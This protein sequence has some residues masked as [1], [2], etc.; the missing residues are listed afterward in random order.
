MQL[1]ISQ[2]PADGVLDLCESIELACERSAADGRLRAACVKT[3]LE[4]VISDRALLASLYVD[5]ARGQVRIP[6]RF[7]LLCSAAHHA[8]L[9][10]WLDVA[11][12]NATVSE[13]ADEKYEGSRLMNLLQQSL[14]A[15]PGRNH[16]AARAATAAHTAA[17]ERYRRE[18]SWSS[19]SARYGG[20][21]GATLAAAKVRHFFSA[22]RLVPDSLYNFDRLATA[23]AEASS[24]ATTTARLLL[25]HHALLRGLVQH[26]LQRPMRLTRGL[27][28][29][30]VWYTSAGD[31]VPVVVAQTGEFAWVS[32]L[33]APEN[34]SA[35]REELLPAV[36]G[37]SAANQR[38]SPQVQVQA[39]GLHVGGLWTELPLVTQ[40]REERGAAGRFP[41]TIAALRSCG[42][43]HLLN[44]RVS[45]LRAQTHI[46]MHCGVSNAKLR[47]HL[48]LH[49]P[50]PD[51]AHQGLRSAMRVGNRTLSW[52]DGEAFVFDDSFEHEVWWRHNASAAA[53]VNNCGASDGSEHKVNASNNARVL[54]MV[55]VFH[56]ELSEHQQH[57]LLREMLAEDNRQQQ[58]QRTAS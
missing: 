47:M 58:Q 37:A 57:K 27:S 26:P 28:A 23:L 52:A 4:R 38:D 30:P 43:P 41:R 18:V 55:D 35:M 56:P 49:V 2:R 1:G 6:E 13:G 14:R 15:A 48:G 50:P 17:L 42:V 19:F 8:L 22:L 10:Q 36:F 29:R 46:T 34:L 53:H 9:A 20:A 51:L 39:E 40:A 45:V 16:T 54:L 24:A 44:A 7:F 3:T 11:Q 12:K 33:R 21:G 31:S 5:S 32:R 25:L